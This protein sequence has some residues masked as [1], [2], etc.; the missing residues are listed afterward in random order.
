MT[1]WLAENTRPFETDPRV[2]NDFVT[3]SV[4]LLLTQSTEP[5]QV[6]LRNCGERMRQ[7]PRILATARDNLTNP[8]RSSPRRPSARIAGPSP[9]TRRV[10]TNWPGRRR[11]S[12]RLREPAQAV[13]KTCAE[14]QTFLQEELLPR[15]TG[16]WRLG[17]ESSPRS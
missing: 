16:D 3:D 15:A 14:Y 17:K 7:I 10:S 11:S 6:N 2:Y 12:A 1:I 8:P 13:V 5:A 4:Y 9:F